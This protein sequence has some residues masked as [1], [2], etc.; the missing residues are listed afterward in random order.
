MKRVGDS[1]PGIELVV[2]FIGEGLKP[3]NEGVHFSWCEMEM[4]EFLFCTFC[5]ASVLECLFESPRYGGPEDFI[6]GVAPSF[7]FINHPDSPA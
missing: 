3:S 6:C 1:G 7:D 2:F 5:S 4:T